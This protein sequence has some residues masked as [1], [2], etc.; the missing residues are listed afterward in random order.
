VFTPVS[1]VLKGQPSIDGTNQ[2]Q[3]HVD[4]VHPHG[5]LHPRNARI[6]LGVFVDVHLAEYTE[7]CDPEDTK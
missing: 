7:D 2:P 6:A 4:Q 1:S 3:K 5:V